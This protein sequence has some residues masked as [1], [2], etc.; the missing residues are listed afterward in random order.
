MDSF[1]AVSRQGITQEQARTLRAHALRF[2]FDCHA[3]KKGGP[4]TA[5]DAPKEIRDDRNAT[6]SI[7]PR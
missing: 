6:P 3:K 5:Q 7:P 2:V 4:T 1:R